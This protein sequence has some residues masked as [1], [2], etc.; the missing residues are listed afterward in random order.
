M[1]VEE[2]EKVVWVV[3]C[4]MLGPM[5]LAEGT[6]SRYLDHW[7]IVP[8]VPQRARPGSRREPEVPTYF[9]VVGRSPSRRQGL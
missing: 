4:G 7:H 8:W 9:T 6:V 1:V 2:E 5:A 3:S